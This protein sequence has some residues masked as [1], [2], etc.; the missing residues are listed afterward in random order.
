METAFDYERIKKYYALGNFDPLLP[1]TFVEN[2]GD[3]YFTYIQ[4]ITDVLFHGNTAV[5]AGYYG[6]DLNVRICE[7]PSLFKTRDQAKMIV[8]YNLMLLEVAHDLLYFQKHPDTAHFFGCFG[9]YV[10]QFGGNKELE[11]CLTKLSEEFAPPAEQDE[12][13]ICSRLVNA[14]TFVTFHEY[15]HQ[16]KELLDAATKVFLARE[17]LYGDEGIIDYTQMEETVCDYIALYM[18]TSPNHPIGNKPHSANYAADILKDAMILQ[19]AQTLLTLVKRSFLMEADEESST[20]EDVFFR[21]KEQLRKRSAALIVALKYTQRS[22]VLNVGQVDMV[23]AFQEMT[24]FLLRFI[25]CLLDGMQKM[26]DE[27]KKRCLHMDCPLEIQD[28]KPIDA[29]KIWFRIA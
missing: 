24:D 6:A 26:K 2:Y 27:I 8:T 17:S 5:L 12:T 7:I 9:K 23:D 18:L 21:V 19:H 22:T 3:A 15:I 28:K 25:D 1:S 29:D 13:E 11:S 20:T 4:R 14:V 10:T 16:D